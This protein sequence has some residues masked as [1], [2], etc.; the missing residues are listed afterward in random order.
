MIDFILRSSWVE[1]G[2]SNF[3]THMSHLEILIKCRFWFKVWGGKLRFFMSNNP[4]VV[5][6]LGFTGHALSNTGLAY[7]HKALE[8]PGLASWPHLFPD[9]IL[10]TALSSIILLFLA[11]RMKPI[12]PNPLIFHHPREP[13]SPTAFYL[14][15]SYQCSHFLIVHSHSQHIQVSSSHFS[16]LQEWWFQ[17]TTIKAPPLFNLP[18]SPIS[19]VNLDLALIVL[20][21]FP[22]YISVP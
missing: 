10:R 9:G 19:N 6:M 13:W 20:Q 22:L 7:L 2:F 1:Q 14:P 11:L 5:L 12:V 18:T 4:P 16:H 3:S 21:T 17:V 15:Y 8:R